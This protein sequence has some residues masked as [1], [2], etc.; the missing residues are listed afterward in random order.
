M[1]G[2]WG[3]PVYVGKA[4]KETFSYLKD[5]LWKKFNG[6]KGFLLSS[7]G[8]EILIKIVAQAIPIY[9]MQTFLLPKTLCDE[10]NQL[11]AQY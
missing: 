4:K 6:W 11:V 1:I 3:L 9:T 10:L 5:W 7:A 8:K 2:T